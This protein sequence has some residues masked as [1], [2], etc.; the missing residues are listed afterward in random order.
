[1]EFGL[2]A[3]FGMV[4]AMLAY[5]K[6]KQKGELILFSACITWTLMAHFYITILCLVIC[7][8]FGL[9]FFI[10]ILRKKVLLRFAA[11][12]LAGVILACIPYVWGY[13]NGYEFERSI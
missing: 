1:M 8:C 3:A 12:G 13:L 6:N 5:I 4:Y 9:V 11:A 7:V 10:P 2:V